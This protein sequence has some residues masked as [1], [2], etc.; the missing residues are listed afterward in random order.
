[1]IIELP[2]YVSLDFVEEIKNSVRPFVS[3]EAKHTYFRDGKSVHISETPELKNLDD[4]LQLFFKE[5]SRNVINIRYRPQFTSG[6]TGYAYHVYEPGH[7]CHIHGDGEVV[8]EVNRKAQTESQVA[9][10][11]YASVII[12]LS[13]P[14]EGGEIVFPAQNKI[15][16]TEAGKVVIFPPYCM[17]QHYTTPSEYPREILVT[18]FVYNN[19][20]VISNE[21]NHGNT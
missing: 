21:V 9:F 7:V 17:Y 11:R 4:K 16:K 6:D 14:K 2:N 10:L 5:L 15:I 8:F 19:L 20:N 3:E 1:M 12:H 13:T 18:W